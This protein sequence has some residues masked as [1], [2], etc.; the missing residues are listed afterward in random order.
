MGDTILQAGVPD[1]RRKGAEHCVYHSLVTVGTVLF[2][3]LL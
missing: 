3:T 2:T 1:K